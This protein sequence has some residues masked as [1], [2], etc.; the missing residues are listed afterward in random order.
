MI[1]AAGAV[2]GFM[3]GVGLIFFSR[4]RLRRGACQDVIGV[5]PA[6]S[7]GDV[8]MTCKPE[9]SKLEPAKRRLLG[10]SLPS[11]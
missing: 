1:T 10:A 2:A 4:R 3:L 6:A 7:P 11:Q 8:Q 9:F 5:R